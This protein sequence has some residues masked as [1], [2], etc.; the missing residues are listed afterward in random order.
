MVDKDIN[1]NFELIPPEG[2][3]DVGTAVAI[4]FEEI[5]SY[6]DEFEFSKAMT[7]YYNLRHNKHWKFK[8]TGLN[9][10][11][12]NMLGT[13][14]KSTVNQ[15]TS[16]DPTFNAVPAGDL[17]DDGEEKLSLM[18]NVTSAWWGNTEQQSVF[19]E[20]VHIGELYGFVGEYIYPDATINFPVGDIGVDTLDPMYFSLYPPEARKQRNAEAFVRWYP[21]TAREAKRLW[22][23]SADLIIPDVD[24]KQKIG[25]ERNE[26]GDANNRSM[27]E[28][29]ISGINKL[30]GRE[31]KTPGK[32]ESDK[33]YIIEIWVRDYSTKST[34]EIEIQI[35]ENGVESEKEIK[36]E[37]PV[38]PGNIRRIAICNGGD[39]VLSDGYNPSLN[40]ALPEEIHQQNYLYSRLPISYTQPTPDPSSPFGLPDFEQLEKL[41]TELDKSLTQHSMF[42]D[43]ASRV[44]LKVPKDTGVDISEFDNKS[45]IVEPSNSLA[46]EAIKY[47]DPPKMGA[48][49]LESINM[50]KEF[51]YEISGTFE[52][53]IQGQNQGQRVIAAQAIAL[54]I[55]RTSMSM[56][57]KYKNYQKMVRER[58][59]MFNALAQMWYREPH[60]ITFQKNGKDVTQGVTRK[61]L[62]IPGKINVV[63][64]STMP[65][66][67]LQRREET[68]TL[69]KGNFVDQ[70][71]VLTKFDIDNAKDIILRMQQGPLGQYL[72]KLAKIGVPKEILT[73]FKKI[74]AT[75]DKELEKA[76]KE[77]KVPSFMQMVKS[78]LGQEQKEK[79]NPEMV[80]LQLEAQDKQAKNQIEVA[81]V[82]ILEQETFSKIRKNDAAAA[83]DAEKIKTEIVDQRVKSNGIDLDWENIKIEKAKA[84]AS[85]QSDKKS[86]RLD[87]VKTKSDIIDKDNK[88]NLDLKKEVR[89]DANALYNER[90]LKSNNKEV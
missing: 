37:T 13:Y 85:I 42:K 66:S 88:Q 15:I 86:Q 58:G 55:E 1:D 25:D 21:K 82:K 68:L 32:T 6:R 76:I 45:G 47:I 28:V 57:G 8:N 24:L 35:D 81:K 9:L 78:L 48:D 77:G 17:G 49:I 18:G 70:E 7:R 61:D 36:G 69:A 5:I 73:V 67:N 16:N 3:K 64:G 63:S 14:H 43:K 41:N 72:Q 39:V 44:K 53:A 22:P 4:I 30:I 50:Y 52:D 27:T 89:E 12:A 79:P 90:G 62:Q 34:T 59:R 11:S 26:E 60:Y 74:G 51:F 87:V 20:S 2:H 71:Y 23:D 19:E 40:P 83:L 38:Y 75:K 80:K 33:T 29:V 46:S 31:D 54:L 84:V 10:I 56:S 65:V